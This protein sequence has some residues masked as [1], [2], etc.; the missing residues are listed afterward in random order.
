MPDDVPT[1]LPYWDDR[2]DP[3]AWDTLWLGGELWPGICEISG[4]GVGRKID[5]KKSKGSD[6]ATLKDEGYQLAKLTIRLTIYSESDWR[7]L[8]ALLPT[9]HPKR[10]GGVRTP[11]EITNPQANLLGISQIYID[12]IGIPK[13]PTSGDG[14]LTLDMS[15]IEWVPTPKPI[16]SGGAAGSAGN[17]GKVYVNDDDPDAYSPHSN[18]VD[19]DYGDLTQY[20]GYVDWDGTREI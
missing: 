5:V 7:S 4:A 19:Q 10:K 16:K 14:L 20:E 1:G 12:K 6:G 13:K 17:E 15:A 18:A 11:L 8:Q 2:D 9:V 3:L